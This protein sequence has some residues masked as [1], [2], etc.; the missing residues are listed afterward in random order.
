MKKYQKISLIEKL[1]REINRPIQQALNCFKKD[2]I[3]EFKK[4]VNLRINSVANSTVQYGPFKGIV[5]S[6][7]VWNE[8]DLSS[9]LLGIY[10]FHISSKIKELSASY[11]SFINLGGGDGYFALGFSKLNPKKK[12]IVF[13]KEFL[14]RQS[15]KLNS[16]AN[17]L[18]NITLLE[19]VDETNFISNL[20]SYPRSL[21]LCDIEGF[22]FELFTSKVLEKCKGCTVIIE[23][24]DT[25]E[26]NLFL[27]QSLFERAS[28][29][30]EIN[31]INS[32]PDLPI[33]KFDIIKD[34]PDDERL[35]AFSEGRPHLMDWVILTPK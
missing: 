9:K 33:N 6:E 12:C 13:E 10:E 19:S 26:K 8:H 23:L 17:S 7:N 32:P 15:I 14:N 5:I 35:L 3:G 4:K 24:H 28:K 29:L 1:F 20:K 27:R 2:H 25:F 18:S 22:E 34:F 16:Q 11:E 31:I 30:F 21:I